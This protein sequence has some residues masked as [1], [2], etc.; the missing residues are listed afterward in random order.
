MKEISPI[1]KKKHL[2]IISLSTLLIG[3]SCA[4]LLSFNKFA[5]ADDFA[6]QIMLSN[7]NLFEWAWER[8]LSFDGRH[9]TIWGIIQGFNIKYLPLQLTIA[10][11][12][13]AF[14]FGIGITLKLLFFADNIFKINTFISILAITLS[15][16]IIFRAHAFETIYWAVG[17]MYSL[18][19]LGFALWWYLFTKTETLPNSTIDKTAFFVLSFLI[20]SSTQNLAAAILFILIYIFFTDKK[21]AKKPLI[22][23]FLL[24]TA[25]ALFISLAP[26]NTSRGFDVSAMDFSVIELINNFVVVIIKY[27][28]LSRSSIVITFSIALLLFKLGTLPNSKN[29]LKKVLLF[30]GA[31]LA[32]ALPFVILPVGLISNRTAIY[33]QFFFSLSLIFFYLFIIQCI[34]KKKVI[35]RVL[36]QLNA[37]LIIGCVSIVP[38]LNFANSFKLKHEYQ[39]RKSI[40]IHNSEKSDLSIPLIKP[41][42]HISNYLNY[43]KDITDDPEFWRNQAFAEYYGYKSAVSYEKEIV[44]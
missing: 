35:P 39:N 34:T 10:I 6:F 24:V 18:M 38:I 16:L 37:A 15:F 19:L 28:K 23:A 32:T 27:L 36:F 2:Q 7:Q 31:A 42:L 11:Y 41:S 9:L 1:R 5:W 14:A 29:N 40:I 21:R 43:F 12:F 33:F 4:F 17:G 8:Y 30:L 44:N 22:I 26:G 25:G 13:L 20:G 3:F